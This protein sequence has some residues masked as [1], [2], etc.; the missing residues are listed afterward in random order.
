MK[1]TLVCLALVSLFACERS[2]HVSSDTLTVPPAPDTMIIVSEADSAV[3]VNIL[4]DVGIEGDVVPDSRPEIKSSKS[5][6]IDSIKC[7]E[8]QIELINSDSF[9]MKSFKNCILQT[10][11]KQTQASGDAAALLIKVLERSRVPAK[12]N[13][14]V[15]PTTR[16]ELKSVECDQFSFDYNGSE[17]VI[18]TCDTDR[19]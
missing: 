6:N 15:H 5:W 4:K 10:G 19:S 13:A 16:W 18:T 3:L 14:G 8:S 1:T 7:S 12:S 11:D 2:S 9:S 17:K